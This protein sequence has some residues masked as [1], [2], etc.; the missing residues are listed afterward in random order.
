MI[1]QWIGALCVFFSATLVG[2]LKAK[3]FIHRHEDLR[4]LIIAFTWFETALIERRL[5]LIKACY[6]LGERV[7]ERIASL[8]IQMA[9]ELEDGHGKAVAHC[10]NQALQASSPSWYF[11]KMELL[12]LQTFGETL[13]GTN[14]QDQQLQFQLLLEQ[15]MLAEKEAYLDE[16][17]FAKMYTRLGML[18]GISLVIILM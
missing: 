16:Q 5:P 13:G 10:W 3:V 15:L 17:R 8:F 12:A 18:L 1:I 11:Q 4:Y 2:K 7:N 6:E 9:K 14:R